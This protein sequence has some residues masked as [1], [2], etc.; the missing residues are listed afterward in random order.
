MLPHQQL[1]YAKS[2]MREPAPAPSFKRARTSTESVNNQSTSSTNKND[3]SSTSLTNRNDESI[4]SLNS[5]LNEGIKLVSKGSPMPK[6]VERL[7]LEKFSQG[8]VGELLYFENIP[9]STGKFDSIR[10][11]LDKMRNSEAKEEETKKED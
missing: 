4:T 1:D 2:V 6:P 5:S 8:V 7:P 10:G 11:L 3:E 9:N